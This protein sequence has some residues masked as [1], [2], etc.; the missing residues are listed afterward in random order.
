MR[1]FFAVLISF[2]LLVFLENCGGGSSDPGGGSD[3]TSPV[4]EIVAPSA[5][6][7]YSTGDTTWFEGSC[8]DSEDGALSGVSLGWRSD[9]DG[10]IGTGER[11]AS[12][13]LSAGTHQ[14]T[15]T[16]TDDDEA[17]GTDSVVITVR[18]PSGTGILPD[19]GQTVSFTDTFGEDADYTI[20]PPAYTKQDASGNDL[21][22]DAAHWVM[23]RD[24]VTGLVW[25]VKTDDGGIHDKDN[26]Y[27]WQDGQEIFIAQLNRDYF[28]GYADW[29]LPTVKELNSLVCRGCFDP[30]IDT[31]YFPNTGTSFRPYMSSTESAGDTGQIYYVNFAYG[32]ICPTNKSNQHPVRAVRDPFHSNGF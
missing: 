8:N 24:D 1:S 12:T 5:G 4:A 30:A 11:C 32:D 16:C 20:N 13:T 22:S 23:V 6:S 29:R 25:E 7:K 14:I 2:L 28:G 26:T 3:N 10:R 21:D 19:T 31:A 9:L 15:L 27:T 17:I 18:T